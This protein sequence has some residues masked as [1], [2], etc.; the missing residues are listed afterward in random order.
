MPAN[1][2]NIVANLDKISLDALDDD[3]DARV[4]VLEAAR[5]MVARLETPFEQAWR[6]SWIG[7][8]VFSV[9][10]IIM[11]LGL[12][13]EWRKAGGKEA[14]LEELLDLCKVPC[15]LMLLRELCIYI[16]CASLCGYSNWEYQRGSYLIRAAYLGPPRT[17]TSAHDSGTLGR[18][19]RSR[20]L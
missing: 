4:Q 16:K 17:I 11:D 10:Q 2:Q 14:S 3:N 13:E 1:V 20:L 5:R 6:W 8:N 19:G 15:D 7:F 9:L 12:W 18:G